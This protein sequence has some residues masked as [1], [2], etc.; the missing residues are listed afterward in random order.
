MKPKYAMLVLSCGVIIA[1]A[2]MFLR[3][4]HVAT[5]V[6]Y[7]QPLAGR[8]ASV[9]AA[10]LL[11]EPARYHRRRIVLEGIWRRG[12]EQSSLE[13]ISTGQDLIIWVDIWDSEEFARESREHFERIPVETDLMSGSPVR[14]RA[15]G[16]FYCAKRGERAGFGHL[17]HADALFVIDR[18]LALETTQKPNKAPEPTP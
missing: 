6:D 2:A 7:S 13:L 14:V 1:I 18:V 4:A 16:S 11:S 17:N 9:T 3:P 15:E 12:F 8:A 5:E 10:D